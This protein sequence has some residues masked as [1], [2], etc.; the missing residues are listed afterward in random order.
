MEK[1]PTARAGPILTV[2][3]I[4]QM[5]AQLRISYGMT[6]YD[7]FSATADPAVQREHG[8][9][10][11][12]T[13][14]AVS[15]VIVSSD[16]N[17]LLHLRGRNM[18]YRRCLHVI[19]GMLTEPDPGKIIRKEIEE[20]L[21]IS[22]EECSEPLLLGIA[23]DRTPGRMNHEFCFRVDVPL[24]ISE[25][26]RRHETAKDKDEGILIPVPN[27]EETITAF[28]ELGDKKAEDVWV[29]TGHAALVL[30]G[31]AMGWWRETG[32]WPKL[33]TGDTNE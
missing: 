23:S 10:C 19:G 11:V 18:A 31:R 24:K 8:E 16:N 33:I 29:P 26:K 17:I 25:I 14:A 1:N 30:H 4:A 9:A 6:T 22:F 13:A 21:G 12:H 3:D 7:W 32:W 28:L 20:E 27:T 5:D 2:R 15:A